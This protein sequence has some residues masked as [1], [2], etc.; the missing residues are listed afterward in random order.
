MILVSICQITNPTEGGSLKCL[1]PRAILRE[2]IGGKTDADIQRNRNIV[3]ENPGKRRRKW[4]ENKPLSAEKQSVE[5]R[6]TYR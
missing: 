2:E 3:R 4:H 5:R 1:S 6:K